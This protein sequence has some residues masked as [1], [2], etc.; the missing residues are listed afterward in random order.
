MPLGGLLVE[1]FLVKGQFFVA[2]IGDTLTRH[3]FLTGHRG[4][5]YLPCVV[6][7]FV[8]STAG[9]VG[10]SDD[11]K[12]VL[13]GCIFIASEATRQCSQCSWWLTMKS[14]VCLKRGS[15]AGGGGG[16]AISQTGTSG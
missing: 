16:G 15:R 9:A 5:R 12:I 7:V 4:L 11:R 13:L 6:C 8:C 3:L 10:S 14:L 1:K 2:K